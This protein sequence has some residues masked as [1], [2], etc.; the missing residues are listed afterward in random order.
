ME[1]IEMELRKK[2]REKYEQ[3]PS[4]K[5]KLHFLLDISEI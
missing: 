3:N 4:K 5:N 1:S 2:G